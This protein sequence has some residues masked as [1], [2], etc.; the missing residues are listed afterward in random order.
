MERLRDPVEDIRDGRYTEKQEGYQ[1]LRFCAEQAAQDVLEYFWIDT[2]C[3][4]RWEN[5]ERSRAINSMFQWYKNAKRCY[6]FLSDVSLSAT[7]ETP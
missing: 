5:N 3:I 6:I 4:D 1:K 2:C 7:T